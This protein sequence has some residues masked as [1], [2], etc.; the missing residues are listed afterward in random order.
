[1]YVVGIARISDVALSFLKFRPLTVNGS[2]IGCLFPFHP[3]HSYTAANFLHYLFT[4][5]RL[6]RLFILA[7]AFCLVLCLFCDGSP[8]IPE[9]NI[10][11]C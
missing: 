1:M 10:F 4:R 9:A 7:V 11:I 3:P 8:A 2:T 5:D 6:F